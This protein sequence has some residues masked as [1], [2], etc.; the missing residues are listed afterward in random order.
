MSD[1]A[2]P[3]DLQRDQQLA[4][5]LESAAAVLQ[6]AIHAAVEAGLKVTAEVESMHHVG[7]HYPEPLVEILVE[8]VIKLA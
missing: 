7:N 5:A 4:Q 8:R 6:Q 2:S 3:L 1:S